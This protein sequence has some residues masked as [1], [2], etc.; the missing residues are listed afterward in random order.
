MNMIATVSLSLRHS[1]AFVAAA[2]LLVGCADEAPLAP[3]EQPE[4]SVQFAS[5]LSA[6]NGAVT[7]V[8]SFDA[9]EGE[10]PES[11][12][13]DRFG[14]IYVSM[15][16]LG[17]IWKLDPSGTF[18][19]VVATF[20]LEGFFGVS[21]LRFDARDNLYATNGSTNAGVH[22]VWRIG[23]G[24]EKERV[25]GTG[26]ISLPNDIA[27]APDGTLYITD[28]AGALWRVLAGGAAEIWVQDESLEGTGAYGLGFGIGA[29]GIVVVPGGKMPFAR[30]SGQGSAGGLVVSNAEKGQVVY[31]PILPDGSAG[32][33]FVVIADP[34][35]FGLDGITMDAQGNIYGAANAGN[36]VVRIN[37]D[38][39]D[40][41][42][43]VSGPPLD[44]PTGL[45]F[46]TGR[47]GHTLFIVNS[48]IIHLLHDPP[49]LDDANPAV[50]AVAVGAP[51]RSNR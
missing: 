11:I 14:N 3:E 29:N 21:G 13:V 31:V 17:E 16:F 38:G 19:E 2:A 12:A 4:T 23:S 9:F 26:G 50:I 35:L 43:I 34:G 47:E 22:G 24:G 51:G 27:F 30:G 39:T 40:F 45:T 33:P 10:L 20:P 49:T 7:T 32:Q 8:T 28:S 42:E 15:S 6:S 5:A 37:R 18:R 48:A 36:K 25:A 1:L 46:G 41:S 44:F